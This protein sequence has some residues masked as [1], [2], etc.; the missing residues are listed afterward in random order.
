MALPLG[1][2]FFATPA[3]F[4]S[5]LKR[6]SASANELI[7]GFYTRDSG[8]P[9]ITWPESVDEALCV[10]WIDGVRKRIDASSYQIR[11]TPRKPSSTWSAINIEKVRMLTDA[12]RMQSSGLKAFTA[13]TA[14]KSQ[15]YAYEQK[16]I[17]ALAPKDEAQFRK[18]KPAWTFFAAQPPSYRKRL[19]WW[20]VNAKQEA[21]RAKRLAALIEASKNQNRL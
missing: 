11:F 1:P 8:L 20:V 15:T 19:L 13:R 18:I 3:A 2:K 9:S 7:V 4:R 10:G 21:T 17:A 16:V 6:N 5:W 14:A 12:G